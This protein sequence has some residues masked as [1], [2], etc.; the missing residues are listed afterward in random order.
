MNIPL[1][2]QFAGFC[3]L[4]LIAAGITMPGVVNLKDH[5]RKLPAFIRRLFW[6]YYSFIGA[7]LLGFGLLSFFMAEELS[8]GTPLAR[9]VCVFFCLFWAMRL[10]VALWVFD[11]RPY[12][13]S[14]LL[15]IGYQATNAVFTLLPM[16]YI[17]AALFGGEK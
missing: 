11:V 1:Y 17:L 8:S 2:L 9:A 3:H 14:T 6:V 4:G 12:L 10:G 13:T 16:I 15:R 5:I 7:C